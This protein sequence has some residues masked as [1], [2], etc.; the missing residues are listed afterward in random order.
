MLTV[1]LVCQGR[2]EEAEELLS[3]V[4][5]RF[6]YRLATWLERRKQAA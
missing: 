6:P 1:L 2:Y 5:A 3:T 4:K